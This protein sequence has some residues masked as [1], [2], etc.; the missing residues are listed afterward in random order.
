MLRRLACLFLIIAIAASLVLPVLPVEAATESVRNRKI[1]SVVVDDSGSMGNAK[2]EYT[3]YAMQCFTAL[4]NKE[5]RLDIT[6][7][8]SYENGAIS[9]DTTDRTSSVQN[10]R[11]HSVGGN[12]PGAS[13][14]TAFK[15]MESHNDTDA[16]TQYWLFVMTDGEMDIGTDAVKEKVDT[17]AETTM[18]NGTKP[19]IV[20]LTICDA[21]RSFTP[22]FSKSNIQSR[23]ADTAADVINAISAIACNISGRYALDSS[24]IKVV[25]DK[26][27]QITTDLP[28]LSIGILTQR[29]QATV[30]KI[31]GQ[32]GDLQED[33]E[34]PVAAPGAY[35]NDMVPDD[36]AALK[37]N[38][39]LFSSSAGNIAAGTYTVTFTEPFSKDDLVIMLE[40]AFELRLE[41]SSGGTKIDDL[42]TLLGGQIVDIE[43]VLY[44]LGTD[45]KILPSMLPKGQQTQIAMEESGQ[46]TKTENGLVLKGVTLNAVETR[47]SATLEI[48]GFFTIRDT[49]TFTPKSYTL[50]DIQAK[51]H[52]DGSPRRTDENGTPDADNVVY[53]TELDSNGTGIEFTLF[54]E[55]QGVEKPVA[56]ALRK[57]FERGLSTAFPGA[58]V[59][60]T[61][62]GTLLVTPS[63]VGM[64]DL[65]YWLSFRGD[66]QISVT[67]QGITASGVIRFEMGDWVKAIW[68]LLKWI[69][70]LA[71]VIYVLCWIFVKPHFPNG[72]LRV[73]TTTT[74][75]GTYNPD[76]GKTKNL[77]W[78]AASGPLN[79]FGPRG[80]GKRIGSFYVRA[81]KGGYVL[82]NVKGKYVSTSYAY[83]SDSVG[84]SKCKTNKEFRSTI[85][86]YSENVYYKITI[87][88]R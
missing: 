46:V 31:S 53:I 3:N 67:V 10:V 42:T 87:G 44:E 50:S 75:E 27:V 29:S 48:P 19:Q 62:E 84:I 25:D 81:S 15:A 4:M 37:G 49:I 14:D 64:P 11:N 43:A 6:Y 66:Q 33:C 35:A 18:P 79:F 30:E 86:V 65:F 13:L 20:F 8:G 41:V 39:A 40:P 22:S 72:K 51:L 2:W 5:D 23:S 82:E 17:F 38:I 83:P 77:F 55:G 56:E 16:N 74:E 70:I 61:D 47:I 7:M 12:T 85:Y 59:S 54:I 57:D 1:I 36:F 26:T 73:F 34:I 68:D 28:L 63:K 21:E 80:M 9:M 58:K 78:L 69:L 88:K 45:N 71:A 32:N 76:F 52:P 24:D 60:V